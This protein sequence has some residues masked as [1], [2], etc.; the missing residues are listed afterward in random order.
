VP[1]HGE[2][3]EL[4]IGARSGVYATGAAAGAGEGVGDGVGVGVGVGAG[5][6]AG[7]DPEPDDDEDD[8]CDGPVLVGPSGTPLEQRVA[9]TAAVNTIAKVTTFARRVWIMAFAAA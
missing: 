2:Q 7:A 9:A 1:W 3:S 5:V 6:G 4:K 8:V